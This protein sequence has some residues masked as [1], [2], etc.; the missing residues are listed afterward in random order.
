M[1]KHYISGVALLCIACFCGAQ[2]AYEEVPQELRFSMSV[3][4]A[5]DAALKQ[6]KKEQPKADPKNFSV[7]VNEFDDHFEINF[8]SNA[9][10]IEE[11]IEDG[12]PYIV[13]PNPHGNKHGYSIGFEV[14]KKSGEILRIFYSR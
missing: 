9:D 2:G 14:S 10:P 8:F 3:L 11:G 13:I 7:V 5:S 1:I 4:I 6:F 12:I